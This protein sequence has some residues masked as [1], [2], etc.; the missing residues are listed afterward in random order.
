MK[1]ALLAWIFKSDTTYTALSKN[2]PV[3]TP[4]PRFGLQAHSGI[5]IHPPSLSVNNSFQEKAGAFTGSQVKFVNVASPKY[6][7]SV[8]TQ[9]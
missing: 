6:P 7:L 3:T 8:C 9:W 2:L 1:T 4:D 5:K